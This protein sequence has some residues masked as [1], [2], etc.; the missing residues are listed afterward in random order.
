MNLLRMP[1]IVNVL[2]VKAI[3]TLLHSLSRNNLIKEANDDE[4]E[5]VVY[6]PTGNATDSDEF[7]AFSWVSLGIHT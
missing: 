2:R 5:T 6:E 3:I 7:R 1:R 4:I